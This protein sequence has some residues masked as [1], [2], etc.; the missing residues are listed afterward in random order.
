VSD[1]GVLHRFTIAVDG[2]DLGAFTECRGLQATYTL[3]PTL[4]GGSLSPSCQLLE[5]VAYG[6][7]TLTRPLD[8]SSGA[9][10]AWFSGFAGD[11]RP[12]TARISA[13]GADGEA[14]C[15]WELQGVVPKQWTGP[16]FSAAA[17]N[18]AIET[19]T[20]AHTGFTAS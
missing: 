13:L 19:L 11:P 4:E 2:V 7:V 8:A 6:D 10:A 12:T 18:V 9:V 1:P 17:S 5:G 15:A 3:K 20:L 16:Q 14:L